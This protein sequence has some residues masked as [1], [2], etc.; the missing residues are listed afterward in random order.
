V[1]SANLLLESGPKNSKRTVCMRA[2]LLV[3]YNRDT[4]PTLAAVFAGLG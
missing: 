3:G 4:N 2:G 1:E